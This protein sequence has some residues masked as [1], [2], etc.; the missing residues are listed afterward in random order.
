MHKAKNTYFLLTKKEKKKK[1]GRPRQ[2]VAQGK[3]P[4]PSVYF[5]VPCVFKKLGD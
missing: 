3:V 4:S 2:E 1:R 5:M